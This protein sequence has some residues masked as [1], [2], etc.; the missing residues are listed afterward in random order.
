MLQEPS[1]ELS[2]PP[3][4]PTARD[5]I[6]DTWPFEDIYDNEFDPDH[7]TYMTSHDP[8]PSNTA[9]SPVNTTTGSKVNQPFKTPLKDKNVKEEVRSE[10]VNSGGRTK[11]VKRT[12]HDARLDEGLLDE[13]EGGA[14]STDLKIDQEEGGKGGKRE[15]KEKTPPSSAHTVVQ[16]EEEEEDG[17]EFDPSAEVSFGLP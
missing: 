6:E 14:G 5:G 15:E 17:E 9:K 11:L 7:S 12:R 1:S 10:L 2:S 3:E 4:V 16:N 8:N 13:Q